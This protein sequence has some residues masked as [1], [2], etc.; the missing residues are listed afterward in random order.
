M[1]HLE[2]MA[3]RSRLPSFEIGNEQKIIKTI[4]SL[5]KHLETLKKYEKMDL[6]KCNSHF[7]SKNLCLFVIFN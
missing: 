4:P 5:I 6:L 1:R 2:S 3:A 7:V